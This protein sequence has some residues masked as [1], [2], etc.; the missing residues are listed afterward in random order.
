MQDYQ[1]IFFLFFLHLF[2]PQR[3]F[4]LK[5]LLLLPHPRIFLLRFLLIDCHALPLLFNFNLLSLLRLRN[6]F[7][8][9]FV[10]LL[11]VILLRHQALILSLFAEA[12]HPVAEILL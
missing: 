9:I 5:Q 7:L 6:L 8:K 4:C 1:N 11:E 3:S 12:E 10:L 2:L